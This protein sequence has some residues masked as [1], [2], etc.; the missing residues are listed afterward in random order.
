LLENAENKTASVFLHFFCLPPTRHNECEIDVFLTFIFFPCNLEGE[1]QDSFSSSSSSS[2]PSWSK[3]KQLSTLSRFQERAR[4]RA[5]TNKKQKQRLVDRKE[6]KKKT[7]T[8]KVQEF[9][10]EHLEVVQ[11]VEERLFMALA[12]SSFPLGTHIS[13]VSV[14]L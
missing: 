11:K 10:N 1:P 7:P 8:I 9:L 5:A 13:Q 14:Q 12:G 4:K 3:H 6:S 2:S